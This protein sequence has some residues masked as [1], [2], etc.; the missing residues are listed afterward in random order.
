MFRGRRRSVVVS[1]VAGVV[2]VGVVPVSTAGAATITACV[3]SDTGDL[4]IRFGAAAK[5]KCPKGWTRVRWSS[6]GA[7]GK[8]GIPGTSGI[9]GIPGIPGQPGLAAPAFSVKDASG[10]VV[11]P[12]VSVFPSGGAIYFVLRDGGVYT[13]LGS[14]ELFSL[15]GNP[16]FK[17]PD[18]SGTAFIKYSPAG[19]FT[20][21]TSVKLFGG[22][23]RVV[24]RTNSAGTFGPASAWKGHGTSE[25]VAVAIQ[26]Y[27]RDSTTGV[28]AADGAPFTGDLI[29]LD[30]V[31]APPDFVGPLTIG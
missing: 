1:L 6:T 13:Y 4:R 7:A 29:V 3:K 23:F 19:T 31:P 27:K 15:G 25:N 20:L 12:L 10:A 2:G 21:A 17:T 18:C 11:G 14:G 8:Q 24:F 9:P 30:S 26:L 28:C 5:R 16:D 22:T